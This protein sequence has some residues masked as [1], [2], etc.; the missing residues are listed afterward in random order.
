MECVH[1]VLSCDPCSDKWSM[2]KRALLTE[3]ARLRSILNA[4]D[5]NIDEFS[6]GLCAVEPSL[7]GQPRR[8]AELLLVTRVSGMFASLLAKSAEIV[9]LNRRIKLH[10]QAAVVNAPKLR[11]MRKVLHMLIDALQDNDD[12]H[13]E[14]CDWDENCTCPLPAAIAKVDP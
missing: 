13:A 6:V 2:E 12:L 11:D 9:D 7:D 4:I 1:N 3:N 8:D 10:E 14:E 5:G